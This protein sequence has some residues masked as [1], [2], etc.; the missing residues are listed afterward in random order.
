MLGLY[1]SDYYIRS[2]HISK[3][4]ISP[5]LGFTSINNYI[6]SAYEMMTVAHLQD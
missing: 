2:Y 6:E 1:L 5:L 3:E 4:S